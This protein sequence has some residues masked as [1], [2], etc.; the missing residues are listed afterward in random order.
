MSVSIVIVGT[1]P[2]PV[3]EERDAQIRDAVIMV[4]TQHSYNDLLSRDGK[5][6][7]KTNIAGAVSKVLSEGKLKVKEVLLTSFVME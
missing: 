7:L 6:K 3:V 4:T 5:E 1:K 2:Q